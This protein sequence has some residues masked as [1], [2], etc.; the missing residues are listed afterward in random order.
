MNACSLSSGHLYKLTRPCLKHSLC[1]A[2]SAD[3]CVSLDAVSALRS[4]PVPQVGRHVHPFLHLESPVLRPIV[5]LD[6]QHYN[7]LFMDLSL[8]HETQCSV[9][10]GAGAGSPLCSQGLAQ[11]LYVVGFSLNIC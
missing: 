1:L 9:T 2:N 7:C 4:L 11:C 10:A 6:T 8:S 5:E 3:P